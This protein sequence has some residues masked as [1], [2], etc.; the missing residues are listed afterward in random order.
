[1]KLLEE[2]ALE[3]GTDLRNAKRRFGKGRKVL[4]V[5]DVLATGGTANAVCRLI[6]KLGGNKRLFVSL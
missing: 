5:D 4:I 3:Y 6:E 1:M 2:Y